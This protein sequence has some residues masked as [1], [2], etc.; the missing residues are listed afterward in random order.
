M[1]GGEEGGDLAALPPDSHMDL[2]GQWLKVSLYCNSW[3]CVWAAEWLA[4]LAVSP[5][6]FIR[7]A[8][9]RGRG[10][11]GEGDNSSSRQAA[12]TNQLAGCVNSTSDLYGNRAISSPLLAD[13]GNEERSSFPPLSL[14]LAGPSS[15]GTEEDMT[16]QLW[17]RDLKWESRAL[18]ISPPSSDWTSLA[19]PGC[20]SGS[21][22]VV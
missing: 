3:L 20:R 2:L 17:E 10:R 15:S 19:P 9:R 5:E 6:W 8:G 7:F 18:R 21:D 4:V 1:E 13:C 16:G 22:A 12:V 14:L 11:E